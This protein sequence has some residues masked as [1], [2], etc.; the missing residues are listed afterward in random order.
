MLVMYAVKNGGLM[1]SMLSGAWVEHEVQIRVWLESV[2]FIFIYL[3][4]HLFFAGGG[5][6]DFFF[7][8]FFF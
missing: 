8:G 6:G 1:F 7:F 2:F 4:I 3:F 5:G